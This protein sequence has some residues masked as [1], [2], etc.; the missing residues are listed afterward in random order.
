[1]GANA[2]TVYY[3][4]RQR[5]QADQ[6]NVSKH[7]SGDSGA[8]QYAGNT[9][10]QVTQTTDPLGRLTTYSASGNLTLFQD[11]L[12]AVTGYP[13]NSAGFVTQRDD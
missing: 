13:Y 8:W 11:S 6:G 5:E 1:M 7:V 12:N 2:T 4:V 3:S 10:G 9:F